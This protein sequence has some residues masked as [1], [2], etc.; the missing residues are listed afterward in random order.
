[1]SD[2]NLTSIYFI[3][4]ESMGFWLWALVALALVL[5]AGIVVGIFTFLVP[6]WTPTGPAR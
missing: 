5:L 4:S 1:M 6:S 3:L 2:F